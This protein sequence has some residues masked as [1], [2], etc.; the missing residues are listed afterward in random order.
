MILD[1]HCLRNQKMD[2]SELPIPVQVFH[3]KTRRFQ[4]AWFKRFPWLHYSRHLSAILSDACSK[5]TALSLVD[6][7]TKIQ[8]TLFVTT[9][10][11]GSRKMCY[12]TGMQWH[13]C[14]KL[15]TTLA[16]L[17]LL[18]HS[19]PHKAAD[20]AAAIKERVALLKLFS[21]VRFLA[22]QG[23]AMRGHDEPEGNLLLQRWSEDV[24]ILRC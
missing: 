10:F 19:C 5:A 2:V 8:Q 4:P 17:L 12:T 11:L 13:E 14:G 18:L 1:R 9:G 22:R 24:S 20:Q 6:I 7:S 21:S 23:L 16:P 15:E 3:V